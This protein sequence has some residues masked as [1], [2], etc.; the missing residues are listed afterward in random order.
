MSESHITKHVLTESIKQ[1]MKQTPL[2]RIS[3]QQIVDNCGLNRQTFYYHFKDK[4]DIVNWIYYTEAV[5][6]IA[7]C[8]NYQNWREGMEKVLAHIANNKS[9]YKNALRTPGENTFKRYFFN[10]CYQLIMAV[11]QELSSMLQVDDED[12]VFIANFYTHAF[13][14]MTTQWIMNEVKESPD[15][16]AKRIHDIVE[17]SMLSALKR[18][19]RE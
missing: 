18:F 19:A 10:V 17:G 4:F 3:I 1:L 14:G 2:E 11:I 13:V 16:F 12:C 7:D 6:N 8:K 15:Q 5:E 9:F